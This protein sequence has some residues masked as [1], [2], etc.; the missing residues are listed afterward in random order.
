MEVLLNEAANAPTGENT[1]SASENGDCYTRE[2][3][4][5]EEFDYE[6]DEIGI[7]GF[8]RLPQRQPV[9]M[10]FENIAFTAS[11][12]FRKGS[13]SEFSTPGGE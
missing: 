11:L 6:Q 4:R 5:Q 3:A 8:S 7:T 12:G 1:A 13:S 9:D 10:H 2:A